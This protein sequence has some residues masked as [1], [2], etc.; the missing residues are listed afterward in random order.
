LQ[1]KKIYDKIKQ[2][3][4]LNMKNMTETN[5]ERSYQVPEVKPTIVP[6]QE[7]LESFE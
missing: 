6:S 4:I 2:V 3:Y 5:L 7:I 1:N